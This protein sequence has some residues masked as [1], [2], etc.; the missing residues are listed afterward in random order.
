MPYGDGVLLEVIDPEPD[1]LPQWAAN[2][3]SIKEIFNNP[4]AV[5]N[6]VPGVEKPET[7]S[8]EEI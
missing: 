5:L 2:L 8:D 1:W 7:E 4:V 6:A 3:P